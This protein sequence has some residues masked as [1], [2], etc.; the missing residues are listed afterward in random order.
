MRD[1]T[2]GLSELRLYQR[3][4]RAKTYEERGEQKGEKGV[5]IQD[6]DG[7]DEYDDR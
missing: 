3:A 2:L 7:D 1:L 4:R 5:K 6:Y